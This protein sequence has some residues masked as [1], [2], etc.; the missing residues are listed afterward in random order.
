MLGPLLFI[1][2]INDIPKTTIQPMSLFADD[3]TVTITCNDF[4]TY[5]YDI[6]LALTSIIA[7]IDNNNLKINLN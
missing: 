4:D 5:K 3:S 6:N 2:Y 1:I 7:W